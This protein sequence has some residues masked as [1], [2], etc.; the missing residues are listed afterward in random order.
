MATAI[1]IGGRALGQWLWRSIPITRIRRMVGVIPKEQVKEGD[2]SSTQDETQCN[3][4][5]LDSGALLPSVPRRA[6]RNET[7]INYDYQLYV[8]NLNASPEQFSYCMKDSGAIVSNFDRSVAGRVWSAVKGEP[9]TTADQL[10]I[11]EWLY[12]GVWF[13]GFWRANCTVVD[14]KGRYAQFLDQD[15][16]PKRGFPANSIFPDLV[17]EAAMQLA[18]IAGAQPKGKLQWHL[19]EAATYYV[20][21]QLVPPP[22]TAH[23]TPLP[24]VQA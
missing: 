9:S 12:K 4:C 3:Q 5:K 6:I 22:V 8:A 21:R 11:T 14:A 18:A 13:D 23:H 10:N 24:P 20:V 2:C 15:G 7:I 17:K 1:P 16:R 19:M